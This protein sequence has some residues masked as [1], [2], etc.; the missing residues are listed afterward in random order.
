MLQ[1]DWTEMQKQLDT[2]KRSDNIEA[3][4]FLSPSVSSV[5]SEVET[6]RGASHLLLNSPLVTNTF[7]CKGCRVAEPLSGCM[8]V[9]EHHRD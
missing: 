9:L 6:F 5:R 3:S 7:L 4:P 1:S 8:N 2:V